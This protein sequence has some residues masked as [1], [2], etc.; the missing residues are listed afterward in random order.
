MVL[1]CKGPGRVEY[2]WTLCPQEFSRLLSGREN[3]PQH[4]VN[5][6]VWLN[7]LYLLVNTEI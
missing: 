1:L 2:V 5:E 6:Q 7:P 3:K 4:Y